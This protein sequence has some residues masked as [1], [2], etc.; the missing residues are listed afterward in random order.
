MMVKRIR[1]L[2]K[3][4]AKR[5]GRGMTQNEMSLPRAL[6]RMLRMVISPDVSRKRDWRALWLAVVLLAGLAAPAPRLLAEPPPAPRVVAV[7]DAHGDFDS[8]VSI[9]QRAELIDAN[10]RWSG[11]DATLVITG[12]FLDRGKKCRSVM[13]LLM[14]LEKEAP[15]RKGRVVVL[16]GN[17]EVMNL[18]GDLRYAQN[19]YASFADSHSEKRRSEAWRDYAKWQKSRAKA[20]GQPEPQIAD[21]PNEDWLKAHPLGYFEQREAFSASGKYGRWLRGLP[22]LAEIDGTLFVH[23]GITPELASWSA[24]A[25]AKRVAEEL[26]GFDALMN[27]LVRHEIILP[28]FT[29][30]EAT[31]AAQEEKA[32]RERELAAKQSA[33]AQEGKTYQPTEEEKNYQATLSDFL[34]YPNWFAVHPQGPL[35]FRGYDRWNDEEGQPQAE[36]VVTGLGVSRI[37]VGHS[38]QKT[39][40][41]TARFGGRVFLIDTGMLTTYYEGGRSS[42]LELLAGKISAVYMDERVLLYDGTAAVPAASPAVKQSPENEELPGGGIVEVPA[43]PQAESSSSA[44]AGH[45]WTGPDGK[46][47][48]FKTDEE[49]LEF[50]R[51]AKVVSVRDIGQGITRPRRVLLEKEGVRMNAIFRDINEERDTAKLASGQIE[52]GFRD[53]YAFEPAAYELARLLGYDN[54][55]PAALRRL[56]DKP[57]S[58]QVWLE[59]VMRE[60]DRQRQ[61]T[62]PPDALHWNRQVQMMRL[63]DALIYNTDRNTGNI[64]I[65]AQWTLWMI[66][67]TRA[68]RRHN[69]PM[70]PNS[71]VIVE[72]TV[73]ERLQKTTDEEI[74]TRLQ[75]YLRRAEID[76]LL[77]RRQKLIALVQKLIAEKGEAEVLFTLTRPQLQAA[78]KAN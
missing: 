68:F 75:P 39:G 62:P 34:N 31:R 3:R 55:P 65:D 36:K 64:L 46:P 61:K 5:R 38:P 50:L 33:A 43:L 13:D 7:G 57:G 23:G 25:I 6:Y 72:R 26:K 2:V 70:H 73:W 16:L 49:V 1:S 67:H 53:S 51:T 71:I 27:W 44:S 48:P 78:Q 19:M 42:A 14:A 74:R 45:V 22:A 69:D 41:I 9:L 77:K 11:R 18:M 59:G 52:I 8:L 54:I 4:E 24:E 60:T 10:L 35:W 56:Y 28:F 76:G 32:A 15:R 58:I 47:L 30:E 66:D 21:A 20:L 17:H 40:R 63:F 37:V 12:D 29:L